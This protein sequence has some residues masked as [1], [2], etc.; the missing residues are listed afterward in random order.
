MRAAVVRAWG[1]LEPGEL[2]EPEPGPSEVLIAVKA[3]GVNFA[4]TLLVA[5]TY[6]EKP[7]LPFSPGLEVA[8]EVVRCGPGVA[9]LRKGDRV[10]GT[11]PFGGFAEFAVGRENACYVLPQ[12]MDWDIA[13][14]F[15]VTYGTAH[16]AMRWYLDLKPG[17]TLV[18]HGAGGG[19][20]L[21]AVECGK[22]IGARVIATAGSDDKL[23]LA[24]AHGADEGINY[25]RED[26]R[27]RIKA[28]TGGEG[29]D[30]VFDPVGGAAFDA[31][32]R[33]T[34]W[35]GRIAVIGFASG[36]VP[37][38]PANILLVKNVSVHGVYWGS[39]R[40]RRPDLLAAEFAELFGWY[41]QGRLRPHVSHRIPLAEAP[42]ALELLTTRKATGK[43]VVTV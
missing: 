40:T 43:V 38:I 12:G 23:A 27:E 16:G 13:A 14:G 26:L 15:P 21:A 24:R 8:G 30:A 32:L 34:A 3:A 7:A 41:E 2:P 19:V 36:K 28:L 37:Q 20:G 10:M 42:R 11:T 25:A 9:R 29:A 22:A 35:G 17:Q 6:Q 31:S 1:R 39:Y 4:D 33:S 5:G 18:V